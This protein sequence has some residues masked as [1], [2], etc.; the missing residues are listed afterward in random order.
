MA[1][2]FYI[3]FG[4][5]GSSLTDIVDNLVNVQFAGFSQKLNGITG[6][7]RLGSGTYMRRYYCRSRSRFILASPE[8]FLLFFFLSILEDS[9]YMARAAFIMDKALHSIGLSGK[10][11]VPMLMGFGCTVPAVM[12]SRTLE[13]EKDR[14]LTIMLTPFMSC[15]AKMSVYSLFIMAF[16]SKSRGLAVLSIYI[17]GL[18]IAIICAFITSENSSE[19]RPCPLCNGAPTLQTSH[20]KNSRTSSL[21]KGKRFL[22]K[23]RYSASRSQRYNLVLPVFQLFTHPR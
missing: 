17:L 12:A 11:F 14:R 2:I 10:S 21:G 4:A 15:S 18:I 13:N 7:S 3:T 1:L 22:L 20:S 8:I 23:S 19:G 9:G 6:S 5:V 16:F